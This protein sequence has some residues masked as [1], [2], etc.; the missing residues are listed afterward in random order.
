MNP[1]LLSHWLPICD[2]ARIAYIPATFGPEV[3]IDEIFRFLE[4]LG[5]TPTLDRAYAWLRQHYQPRST[6]WRWDCCST[7]ILKASASA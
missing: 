6:M 2:R 5:D 3:R 4:G 1:I 7:E